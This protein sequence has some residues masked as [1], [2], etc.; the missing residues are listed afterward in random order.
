MI[1][2]YPVVGRKTGIMCD[3]NEAVLPGDILLTVAMVKD[4]QSSCGDRAACIRFPNFNGPWAFDKDHPAIR[5]NRKFHRVDG[6]RSKNY[7]SKLGI[8][9]DRDVR[10]D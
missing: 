3:S 5:R 9:S 8:D 6:V 7:L 2:V 1:K 10:D 4:R